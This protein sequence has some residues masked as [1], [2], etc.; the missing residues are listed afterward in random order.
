MSSI[1]EDTFAYNPQFIIGL[2]DNI[3]GAQA[4]RNGFREAVWLEHGAF[5]DI[6]VIPLYSAPSDIR[7]SEVLLSKIS[8]SIYELRGVG[9][10]RGF[11]GFPEWQSPSGQFRLTE[12]ELRG[13][14]GT[15][16]QIDFSDR[17]YDEE[18]GFLFVSGG[19]VTSVQR[20][21]GSARIDREHVIFLRPTA[22]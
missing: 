14:A 17:Q 16:I 13:H 21:D 10:R 4:F 12:F 3:A 20:E 18:R 9:G 1:T 22:K 2:P 6:E 8:D 19:R 5:V 11:T 15:R 7:Q